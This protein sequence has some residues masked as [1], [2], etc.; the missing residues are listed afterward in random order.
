MPGLLL[1]P[2]A[3]MFALVALIFLGGVASAAEPAAKPN[4]VIILA[5]AAG[6]GVAIRIIVET[7]NRIEGQGEYDCL[8]ALGEDVASACSVYDWPQ[9]NRA[10][11]DSGKIGILHVK[12]AVADGRRL[13]LSIANFTEYAF[14]INMELGLL[15]TGGS[16]RAKWSCISVGSSKT[17][18]CCVCENVIC[19]NFGYPA[20]S[21]TT[22]SAGI[23][24]R[25]SLEYKLDSDP[26][27]P[28]MTRLGRAAARWW[29]EANVRRPTGG[30]LGVRP[31]LA[32]VRCLL[33]N[34]LVRPQ[35]NLATPLAADS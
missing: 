3:A 9:E 7:P 25:G 8:L 15:V 30:Q 10:K 23:A 4:V 24:V 5:A 11:D 27:R 2:R 14:T 17:R 12:C 16:C 28:R 26:T 1:T 33:G 31:V 29:N 20:G 34:G 21:C 13:F 35:E 19:K 32:A 22:P 18:L 6:R